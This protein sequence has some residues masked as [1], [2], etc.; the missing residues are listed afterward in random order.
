MPAMTLNTASESALEAIARLTPLIEK[1]ADASE[2]ER[3][4]A[5]PIVD[6]FREAALFRQNT[7]VSLGGAENGAVNWYRVLEACARID[8]SAGWCLFINGATG[9][10]GRTMNAEAAE[11][12][13]GSGDT[14]I[15]GAVFPF[16]KAVAVDGGYRVTGRWAFAS[17]CRHAT[18]VFGICMLYDGETPRAGAMGVPELRMMLTEAPQA[19]IIDTWDVVGLAGTGSHDIVFKDLFIPERHAVPMAA[20]PNEHYQ[21]PLYR[22]PFFTLFGWPMAAVALGIAQH[23]IDIV[24]ELAQTKT[25]AGAAATPLRERPLFHGQLADAVAAVRSARAWLHEAIGELEA[26]AKAG[27]IADLPARVNAQLA[28]SNATRS[29]R[30]AVDLMFLAGGGTAIY[31]KNQLQRCLRDIHTLSQH[32]ATSPASWDQSGALLAGMPAQNALILL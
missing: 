19:E 1:H 28:A 17:G 2:S 5:R 32:A 23:A 21:G 12:I 24:I 7:P 25:P 26:T 14:V 20:A 4:L 8:G 11:Q 15:A 13:A 18:H 29:A 9:L 22:M 30:Q 27:G 3:T 6:A 16:G 31:R 10:I